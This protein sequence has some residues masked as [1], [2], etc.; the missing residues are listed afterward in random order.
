MRRLTLALG[1]VLL[2]GCSKPATP[3]ACEQFADHFLELLAKSENASGKLAQSAEQIATALR[4][5]LVDSCTKD[6]TAKEVDCVLAAAS[7]EDVE[8]NCR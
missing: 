3:E 7:I 6:A 2:S 4:P 1:L 8:K 5:R